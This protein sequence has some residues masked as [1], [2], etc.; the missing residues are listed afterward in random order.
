MKPEE[1]IRAMGLVLPEP[2]DPPFSFVGCRQTGSLVY[3]SGH[4]PRR[5]DGTWVSGRLGEDISIADAQAAGRLTGV[6]M[7][8]T[9]KAHT[10]DLNRVKQVIKLLCLVNSTPHFHEHPLVA[11]GVSDFLVE[12]FG[13]AGRHARS[14]FGVTA[15]FMNIPIEVEMIV[16]LVD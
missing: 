5:P 10:G 12:V 14:A 2:P 8:A 9:L 16:E 15:F 1:K 11:N 3:L 6:N 4:G 7:L 13:E